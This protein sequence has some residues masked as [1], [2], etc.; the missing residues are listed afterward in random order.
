MNSIR[1]VG[2]LTIDAN[3]ML[4]GN[5]E[6]MRLGDRAS[7]ERWRLRTVTKNADRIKPIESLLGGSLS[8]FQIMRASLIN[9]DHT[10][11]PFGFNYTFQSE[12]LVRVAGS[13]LLVGPWVLGNK[14]SG[15]LG[16]KVPR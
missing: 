4:K 15:R 12:R 9:L 1:R 13:L 6:E 7:S 2:K 5:V 16:A 8:S 3:G 11:Q 10:D 14:S